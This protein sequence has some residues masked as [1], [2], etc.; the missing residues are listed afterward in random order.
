MTP[1]NKEAMMELASRVESADGPQHFKW[2][3]IFYAVFGST[4]DAIA[5]PDAEQQAWIDR[6]RRF[7]RL[8][9][10]GAYLDAAMTLVPDWPHFRLFRPSN[11]RGAVWSVYMNPHPECDD[12]AVGAD[13]TTKELAVLAACLRALSSQVKS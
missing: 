5:L 3:D 13:A 2:W 8:I 6:E 9:E 11:V 7:A 10:A 1:L 4:K 12:P